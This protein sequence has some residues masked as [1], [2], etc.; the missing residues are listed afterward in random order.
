MVR[1]LNSSNRYL[2]DAT[3]G[4][5]EI[6]E[7]FISREKTKSFKKLD[8]PENFDSREAWPNCP[9]IGEIRDQ[10][11]CGSCWAFGASE[12]ITDR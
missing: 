6:F 2:N 12:A 11:S 1:F 7:H 8:L 5:S 3:L 9:S 4:S 10:G